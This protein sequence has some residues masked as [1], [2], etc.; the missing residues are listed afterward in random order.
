MTEHALPADAADPCPVGV[1]SRPLLHQV[2]PEGVGTPTCESLH[3]YMQRLARSHRVT[4]YQLTTFVCQAR[5]GLFTEKLRLPLRL[6]SLCPNVVEF[7]SRVATLTQVQSVNFVGLAWLHGRVA[8]NEKLKPKLAWCRGCLADSR[9]SRKPVWGQ[10]AWLLVN[11]RRCL[12]HDELLLEACPRCGVRKDPR[13]LIED[14]PLET[15]IA[16][17]FDLAAPGAEERAYP[18]STRTA[19]T[20]DAYAA[21]QIGELLSEAPRIAQNGDGPDIRR[22]YLSAIERGRATSVAGLN[23]LAGTG[24][25]SLNRGDASLPTVDVLLRLSIA[26]DVS[27]AGLFCPT[28]WRESALGVPVG[29]AEGRQRKRRNR[30]HDWKA[31]RTRVEQALLEGEDVSVTSLSTALDIEPAVLVSKLGELAHA[32]TR[33]SRRLML[34]RQRG[35][36]DEMVTRLEQLSKTYSYFQQRLSMAEASRELGVTRDSSI[37]KAAWRTFTDSENARFTRQTLFDTV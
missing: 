8:C 34:R 4:L 7:T 27:L 30:T 18:R 25:G 21:K 33:H 11:S 15:C 35:Q 31:I 2:Q 22:L 19:Q 20:W 28:V 37:L 3:A 12:V 26:A 24:M 5:P 6:D 13:P 29:Y 16:C 17:G 23:A 1:R 36:Q 10:T 9:R 14:S 32:V